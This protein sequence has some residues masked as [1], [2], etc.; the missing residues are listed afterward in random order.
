M[1]AQLTTL[2]CGESTI[3]SP[4][5]ALVLQFAN[6]VLGADQPKASTGNT[7]IPAIGQYWPGQGGVNAGL[8]RG[9]DGQ[10]DYWLIVPDVKAKKLAYGGYKADE[11]EAASRRD[12]FA[13]TLHLVEGSGHDHPAA[14]WCDSLTVEGHTDLYLPAISELA[15]CMANVPELFEKQWHLSSTQRS[16]NFA[17]YM[18][19]VVGDQDTYGKG[20]T[21]RVRPVRRFIR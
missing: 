16:A 17:F 5:K 6:F 18:L 8:M 13:N 21:A 1:T 11:P 2:T 20:F 10:P 14:E 19:F 3:S 4:D 15:L 7:D 9:E 12:G